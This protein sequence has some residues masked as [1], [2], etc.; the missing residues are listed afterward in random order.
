MTAMGQEL[1]DAEPTSLGSSNQGG[2]HRR[3][4]VPPA[5]IRRYSPQLTAEELAHELS[6]IT[7]VDTPAQSHILAATSISAPIPFPTFEQYARELQLDVSQ[8]N[9]DQSLR[10]Q[11]EFHELIQC[12]KQDI[13]RLDYRQFPSITAYLYES[14]ATLTRVHMDRPQTEQAS[15][16]ACELMEQMRLSNIS[17]REFPTRQEYMQQL[18]EREPPEQRDLIDSAS[19]ESSD[20]FN[21]EAEL[22]QRHLLKSSFRRDPPV[23]LL[24]MDVA[25]STRRESI[26]P[27]ASANV[28][29]ESGIEPLSRS[30]VQQPP[31]MQRPISMRQRQHQ[32]KQPSSNI[33]SSSSEPERKSRSPGGASFEAPQEVSQIGRSL[34]LREFLTKELLKHRTQR[35]ESLSGGSDDS[36]KSHF[37][38][39]VI[40]SLS[41]SESPHTQASDM[42][43]TRPTTDRRPQHL[44]VHYLLG[45]IRVVH[46]T[47][48]TRNCS[49][50]T[51][52]SQRFTIPTEHHRYHMTDKISLQTKDQRVAIRN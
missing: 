10:M 35:V 5:T 22:R 21:V 31:N 34:N 30:H 43:Q 33:S 45:R 7:E 47:A 2:S 19:L 4:K 41:R 29:N 14:T 40:D 18:L 49:Q 46:C 9:A 15:I 20:S 17:I 50:W 32:T 3:G 27:N 39:S 38:R 28:P 36:L 52:V 51:V 37:L 12:I 23:D 48:Q 6:T 13:P 1:A 26:P 25:S 11:H 24:E 42:A 16:S 8:M 44:L